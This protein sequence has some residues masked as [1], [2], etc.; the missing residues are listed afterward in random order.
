MSQGLNCQVA[1]SEI[2]EILV[3]HAFNLNIEDFRNDP[4]LDPFDDTV[5]QLERIIAE[6]VEAVAPDMTIGH[7]INEPDN[8]AHTIATLR[9]PPKQTVLGASISRLW[10][11]HL[12][13]LRVSLRSYSSA[14]P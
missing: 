6:P 13:W 14:R 7:H 10:R 4:T 12:Y 1:P 8:Y 3:P 2:V 9:Q 11:F 5:L